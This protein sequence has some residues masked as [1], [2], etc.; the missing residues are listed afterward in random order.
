MWGRSWRSLLSWWLIRCRLFLSASLWLLQALSTLTAASGKAEVNG[1]RVPPPSPVVCLISYRTVEEVGAETDNGKRRGGSAWGCA[2]INRRLLSPASLEIA[3]L[4][5][6]YYVAH[7]KILAKSSH[8]METTS[9]KEPI[10]IILFIL[11][12]GGN[13]SFVERSIVQWRRTVTS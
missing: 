6:R 13:V 12:P 9:I 11:K 5:A 8:Q 3:A 10:K 2:P 7:L 1:G 4:K